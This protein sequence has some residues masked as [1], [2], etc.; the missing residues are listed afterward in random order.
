MQQIQNEVKINHT[1]YAKADFYTGNVTSNHQFSVI[2]STKKDGRPGISEEIVKFHVDQVKR[3]VTERQYKMIYEAAMSGKHLTVYVIR[4][5]GIKQ[6][7]FVL[8][9]TGAKVFD[10]PAR[11][12]MKTLELMEN[13]IKIISH[14]S[15]T[16]YEILFAKGREHQLMC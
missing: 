1:A 10:W 5:K 16:S 11:D 14:K 12:R 3:Y 2:I 4:T 6:G 8:D 13:V 7:V 9:H 15:K